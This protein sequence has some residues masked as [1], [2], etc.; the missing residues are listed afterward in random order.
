MVHNGS[1]C[2]P[3]FCGRRGDDGFA[4]A[5][6]FFSPGVIAAFLSGV[7]LVRIGRCALQ[8]LKECVTLGACFRGLCDDLADDPQDRGDAGLFRRAIAR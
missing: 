3:V 1:E 5:G 6:F 4:G 2:V 7:A 8:P